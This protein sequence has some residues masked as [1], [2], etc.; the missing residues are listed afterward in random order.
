[1]YIFLNQMIYTMNIKSTL[2]AIAILALFNLESQAQDTY[3]QLGGG[4]AL[5][6]STSEVGEITTYNQQ[7]QPTRIENVRGRLGAG[8]PIT[9][10]AGY[11]ITPNVGADI[12]FNYLISN[13]VT[14]LEERFGDDIFAVSGETRQA[15]LNPAIVFSTGSDNILSAY[16]RLGLVLPIG[17]V[18]SLEYRVPALFSESGNSVLEVEEIRGGFSIGFSGTLGAEYMVYDRVKIFAELEA[19]HL[20]LPR[21]TSET[22]T[23][24]V[25]GQ[26]ALGNLN[27]YSRRTNYVNELTPESNNSRLN[28]SINPDQ[29]LDELVSS[30]YFNSIGLNIGIRYRLFY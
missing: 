27:N 22:T 17:G 26:D 23:F 20:S 8:F 3:L 12:G 13:R 24:R 1:L 9:L 18:T 30:T 15:R 16:G 21:N 4:F 6:A 25:G 14:I 29:P 11:M 28:P 7:G 19:I 5:P 2:L 10:R